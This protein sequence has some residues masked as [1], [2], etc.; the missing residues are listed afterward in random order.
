M[1]IRFLVWRLCVCPFV[2]NKGSVANSEIVVSQAGKP[3][4]DGRAVKFGEAGFFFFRC[5]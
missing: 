4:R 3:M 2:L 5:R 1:E